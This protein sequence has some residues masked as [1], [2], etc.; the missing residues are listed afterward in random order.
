MK[1][2]I[3]LLLLLLMLS[4]SALAE[5]P[6]YVSVLCGTVLSI[7][8]SPVVYLPR[9]ADET[10]EEATSKLSFDDVMAKANRYHVVIALE[11][12]DGEKIEGVDYALI[13]SY[14]FTVKSD[15]NTGERSLNMPFTVGE[16]YAILTETHTYPE[17]PIILATIEP[18]L[19]EG[20]NWH[21]AN[22]DRNL[23]AFY[24]PENLSDRLLLM[25]EF[26]AVPAA[27]QAYLE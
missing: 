19:G 6:Q 9:E 18:L 23:C 22:F 21:I 2:L 14:M 15:P 17:L 27:W 13:E 4:S 24:L 10:V 8:Q 5:T 20:G 26:T 16:S 11:S 12:V 25:N 3:I 7:T 1:R